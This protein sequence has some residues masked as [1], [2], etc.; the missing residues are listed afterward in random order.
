MMMKIKRT[1]CRISCLVTLVLELSWINVGHS[2]PSEGGIRGMKEWERQVRSA[3]SL[4]EL[5]RLADFPDWKLWKC[6]LRLQQPETLSSPPSGGSHR[7]TRYAA[8]S[9]S[10]EI[11]KAID[12]EWQRTQCMPRETCVDVAK[13]LGTDP[14]MFFKPPCV[15]V[16]RC[17]GCCNQEGVTCKNTT[18]VYVNKTVLSVIPFK[19]V[20]EPVLIKVA[21]HTECRCME[22]AIIRRNAQPHRSS[23][24]S[25]MGQ[26]SEAEDSRRLCATGLIWDCSSDRCIPYPSS[27]PDFPLTSWMPDCEIDV[28]RCDC[29]PRP[30]PPLPPRLAHRCQLN[31]SICDDRYQR[32]DPATCRCKWPK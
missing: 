3:S 17:S 6:R 13:E 32:F 7:S 2:M 19:F 11:L 26:L 12:E 5:L 16:H 25:P 30:V 21:N 29:L 4:D 28:E 1:L 24:C 18:T 15:S 8:E 14:S 27:A 31:S 10:L 22:P 23:G 20:P 9:Y